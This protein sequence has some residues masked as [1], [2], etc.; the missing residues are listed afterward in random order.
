MAGHLLTDLTTMQW[1]SD[2]PTTEFTFQHRLCHAFESLIWVVA[3]AM[4]VH[5][6]NILATTDPANCERYKK[7]LEHCWAAH[8]YGN[9]LRTHSNMVLTGCTVYAQAIVNLWFPDLPEAAFFR[10]AMCLIRTQT[11]GHPI[12]YE[13]LCALFE[14]HIKL[15]QES[16]ACDIVFE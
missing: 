9:L 11:D 5:H 6:R 10:D 1:Y 14:K 8:A 4:M 2:G 16:R 13:G 7:V 12:M 3:Y 15:A